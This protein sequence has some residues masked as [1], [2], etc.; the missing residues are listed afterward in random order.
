MRNHVKRLVAGDDLKGS[1][2]ALMSECGFQSAVVLSV[3][4]SLMV[5][6]LRAAGGKN[7]LEIEGPLEIVGAT[8]TLAPAA[9]HVHLAIADQ[10]GDVFGGHLLDGCIVSSTVEV[11]LT[12]VAGWRFGRELDTKTGYNELVALQNMGSK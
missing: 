8:G 12:E 7:V 11:V 1:L 10:K 5:A 9:M 4:G 3:V 2:A 6:H